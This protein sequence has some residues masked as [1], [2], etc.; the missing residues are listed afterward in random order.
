MIT[1][2]PRR[3][4]L[5]TLL[6]PAAALAQT[7]RLA[8]V[9]SF[10]ILADFVQQIGG[11]SVAVSSLVPPD[12]DPHD[13]Q[14]R[15]SDLNRLRHAGVIVENGLGL[16]G[17]LSR[18]VRSAGFRGTEVIA[19]TG[20]SPRRVGATPD[21]HVWQDPLL[22]VQMVRQIATGLG[23]AD[24]ARAGAYQLRGESYAA[25]I[26]QLDAEIEA[27]FAAILA[28]R[29]RIIT[30]HDAFAYYGSRYGVTFIAAQGISTE[31]EP[32]ARAL[33]EL[34]AQMRKEG[35]QT[36]FLE[37]MT[38][39]RI[40]QAIAREAGATVGPKLYSDSLSPP[41]GPAPTYLDMLRYNTDRFIAALTAP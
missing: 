15:P 20:I 4:L 38:D 25:R 40:A 33:G 41:G 9:A 39:P 10:S 21:P 29:R 22:A 35:I 7:Q 3:A 31:A 18:T 16:E 37:N 28:A 2:L 24:P 8:V 23:G 11:E 32:S 1:S 5:P 12:G 13:F 17:W 27:R 6:L 34:A 26:R 19:T 36:V 14:P 30:T